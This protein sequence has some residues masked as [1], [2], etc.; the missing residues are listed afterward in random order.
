MHALFD[1]IPLDRV[2]T[3]LTINAPAAVLIAMYRVVG[4]ERGVPRRTSSRAPTQNDI[5]K[6]YTA[7]NEFIF[8]PEPSVELVVDTM[9]YCAEVMPR[10]NPVS[11]CGYHIREAGSTA[12]E[13]VALTLAAGR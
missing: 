12:V 6:E 10:F 2:S 1:G 9:E 3:S 13:E 11:V 8:P 4:D 5:L 7:Q